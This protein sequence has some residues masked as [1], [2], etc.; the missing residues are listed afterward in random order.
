MTPSKHQDAWAHIRASQMAQHI[1]THREYTNALVDMW[2]SR[3]NAPYA[4]HVGKRHAKG[5]AKHVGIPLKHSFIK[6]QVSP[7]SLFP[8]RKIG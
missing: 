1:P 5:R 8:G 6:A 4:T 2:H 3:R 7:E